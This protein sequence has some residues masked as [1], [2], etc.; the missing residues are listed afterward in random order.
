[1]CDVKTCNLRHPR[2]C[3]WFRDYQR[4]KFIEYCSY[5]YVKK[6]A[7]YEKLKK[8]NES[9][10]KKIYEIEKNM[11]EKDKLLDSIVNS[12]LKK[13]RKL[14]EK[15]FKFEKIWKGSYIYNPSV[16]EKPCIEC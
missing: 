5:S 6:V 16:A 11:V 8:E 10:E 1:M 7:D 15:L 4:C 3:R 12:M 14:E 2:E 13:F 9:F